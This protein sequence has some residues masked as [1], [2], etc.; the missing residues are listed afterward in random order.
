LFYGSCSYSFPSVEEFLLT[1]ASP[2]LCPLDETAQFL[3]TSWNSHRSWK[4]QG[5]AC[6]GKRSL[7]RAS[8]YPQASSETTNMHE[9]GSHPPRARSLER[10][11][12][13][14]KRFSLSSQRR[15]CGFHRELFRVFWKRK[16]K[17]HA[18]K[19]RLSLE[20]ISLIKQMSA[21]NRRLPGG[22][23][24]WRVAQAG[25]SVKSNGPSKSICVRFAHNEPVDRIGRRFFTIMLQRCGL[26]M[27][28]QIT[29]LFF[30]P[31]FAFF[32]TLV[33][34]HGR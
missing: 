15:F 7:T 18:R 13:G 9:D 10:F 25:Y 11:G 23:H 16:S 34:R 3:I 5:G 2:S 1:R 31:L 32:N 14:S 27:R 28:L 4:K 6:G 8:H 30:R 20:M 24:S 33:A 21:N 29:D 17:S 19:P 22:A 12:H 26:V